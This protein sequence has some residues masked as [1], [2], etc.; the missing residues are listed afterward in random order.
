MISI[1]IVSMNREYNLLKSLNSWIDSNQY[2]QDI[3]LVDWSSGN[4]LIQ[5]ERINELVKNKK[6]NLVEVIDEKVFSLPKSYNLAFN[7]TNKQNKYIIKLD[8]DYKLLDCNLINKILHMQDDSFI[9]GAIK[10]HYTGFFSIQ[11]SKFIYY[12]ENF[13]G[14]G[15]DDLDLYNRLK[16]NNLKE[17]IFS[18]IEKYIYHI[19]HTNDDSVSNY[20]IKNKTQSEKNNRLL[21]S[22]SFT[23]S[24][25]ETVYKTDCYERVKRVC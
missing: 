22:E 1:I 2:I 7:K 12:N 5:N 21:A 24:E 4:S 20:S 9:R 11:R 10:S 18:D 23:I 17:I 15:Y 6:I 25:Y 19:P 3:V 16:K 8:S 13:N 14:W